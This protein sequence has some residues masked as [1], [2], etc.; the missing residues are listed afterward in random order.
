MRVNTR[1]TYTTKQRK[2][3]LKS[4]MPPVLSVQIKSMLTDAKTEPLFF[5]SKVII[6]KW[7]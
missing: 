2:L 5:K 6:K 1:I 4:L 7:D 3:Y